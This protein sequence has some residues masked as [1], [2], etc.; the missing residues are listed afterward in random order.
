MP[1]HPDPNSPTHVGRPLLASVPSTSTLLGLGLTST[2][3]LISAKRLQVVRIGRRTLVIV[4]SIDSLVASLSPPENKPT[5]G[6]IDIT[7]D[8]SNETKE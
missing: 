8:A 5:N 3:Q 7:S 6:A 4:A 2:W 1:H